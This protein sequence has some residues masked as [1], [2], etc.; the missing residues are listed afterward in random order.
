MVSTKQLISEGWLQCHV[1]LELIGK[2]KEHVEKT[3]ADYVKKIKTDK[4]IEVI[5]DETAELK[6][7]DTGANEDG[8]IKQMWTTFAEIDMLI[9]NPLSLTQFCF[10]YMPASIEII[11]PSEV[12]YS[13]NDFTGFFNDLQT[14]LHQLDMIAKQLKTE[15]LFLR[16]STNNLLKNYV[17]LL[18][19]KKGFTVQ[20]LSN[21]TGVESKAIGDF[22]DKLEDEGTVKMEGELYTLVKNDQD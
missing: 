19:S 10:D 20:Q 13:R 12:K 5:S 14:R 9:K 22:L 3:M 16:K 21:L 6:S 2:P 4:N 17:T 8:M 15:V 11:E 18:L 7:M 1:I